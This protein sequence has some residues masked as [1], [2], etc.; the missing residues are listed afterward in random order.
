MSIN[1]ILNKIDDIKEKLTD[2][3]YKNLVEE[4]AKI[5]N[6]QTLYKIK[7]IYPE[8]Q[9][10]KDDDI[11]FKSVL[12]KGELIIVN[13]LES[14]PRLCNIT[15]F[16]SLTNILTKYHIDL[17]FECDCDCGISRTDEVYVGYTTVF[18]YEISELNDFNIS[19]PRIIDEDR[20]E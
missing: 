10:T 9:I 11:E 4:L 3:E 14:I 16:Q 20:H 18:V 6:T 15:E 17:Y 8:V 5:K 1:N 2:M 13:K 12:A 19:Y 7:Y